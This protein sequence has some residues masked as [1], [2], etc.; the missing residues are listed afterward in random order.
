MSK[1]FRRC[2]NLIG[3]DATLHHLRHTFA[4]NLLKLVEACAKKTPE[5][6]A[7]KIVQ[8]LMGHSSSAT[9]ET[10]LRAMEVSSAAVRD[11]LD[12]LYGATL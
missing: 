11:A 3:S 10:Y 4:V 7:L 5:I 1:E 12:Y 8:V 2:A 6:N 9:T